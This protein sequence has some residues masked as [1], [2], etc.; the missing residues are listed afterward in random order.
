MIFQENAVGPFWLSER[1]I[2]E[3]HH[4]KMI[5]GRTI[6]RRHKKEELIG[7]LNEGGE[8]ATGTLA[9]SLQKNAIVEKQLSV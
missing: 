4:S 7:K 3:Q 6:R 5:E 2:D 8:L 1:E 9:L